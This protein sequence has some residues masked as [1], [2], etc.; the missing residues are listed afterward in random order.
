MQCMYVCIYNEKVH[1]CN[2]FNVKE[3]K[4]DDNCLVTFSLTSDLILLYT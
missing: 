4:G 2:A 3:Q 1:A